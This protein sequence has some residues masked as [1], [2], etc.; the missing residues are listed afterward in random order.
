[1]EGAKTRGRPVLGVIGNCS[2]WIWQTRPRRLY[3]V[4][5]LQS[6]GVG[7]WRAVA[8]IAWCAVGADIMQH[9]R[10]PTEFSGDAGQGLLT[11][12]PGSRAKRAMLRSSIR[13][14][15]AVKT[16]P[17]GVNAV[18]IGLRR[19]EFAEHLTQYLG[20]LSPQTSFQHRPDP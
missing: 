15:S 12:S 6:N 3:R 8:S 16:V 11:Y 20:L 1:M 18:R 14:I 17:P 19:E 2:L 4:E 7:S 9:K 13:S 5:E 10:G